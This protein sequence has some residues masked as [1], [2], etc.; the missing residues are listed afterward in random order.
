MSVAEAAYLAGLID[1]EGSIVAAKRNNQGRTTYR[2]QVANT[3]LPILEWCVQTTGVGTIVKRKSRNA[4][5][6]D[7]MWWQCYS[8]NAYDVLKQTLPYML[9][10]G[11]KAKEMMAELDTIKRVAGKTD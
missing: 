2:L 4:K 11:D 5:H 6:K 9:L 10:K 1:G 7:S 8:W 3:Y